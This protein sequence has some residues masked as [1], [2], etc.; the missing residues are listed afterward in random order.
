MKYAIKYMTGKK[1]TIIRAPSFKEAL[2]KFAIS[3]GSIVSNADY[4]HGDNSWSFCLQKPYSKRE[5]DYLI[6]EV[7]N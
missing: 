5:Y 1:Y 6:K 7:K 3:K 4:N 2:A